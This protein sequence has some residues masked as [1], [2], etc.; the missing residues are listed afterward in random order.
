MLVALPPPTSATGAPHSSGLSLAELQQAQQKALLR[1]ATAATDKSQVPPP[2]SAGT[3]ASAAPWAKTK[4][5][6]VD[7]H[8]NLVKA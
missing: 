6:P 3:S 4:K 8:G 5:P 1:R 7:E 2:P